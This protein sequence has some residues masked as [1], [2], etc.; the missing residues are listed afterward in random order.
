MRCERP[1][2]SWR[3]AWCLALACSLPGSLW[4]QEA[5]SGSPFPSTSELQSFEL[6]EIFA[7]SYLNLEQLVWLSTT[8]S[9]RMQSFVESMLESN[10]RLTLETLS[11]ER[12]ERRAT[13][14]LQTA[15]SALD[16]SERFSRSLSE[17]VK[18]LVA[19]VAFWRVVAVVAAAGGV[20]V[21]VIW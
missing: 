14:A 16:S 13:Q 15:W 7:L 1:S 2:R 9:L 10:E 19:E 3:L 4:A 11:S 6:S 5:S 12:S 18:K 8:D 21:A 20:A 17:E